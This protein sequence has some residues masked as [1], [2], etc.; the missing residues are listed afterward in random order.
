MCPRHLRNRQRTAPQKIRDDINPRKDHR[1][2]NRD[3]RRLQQN[4]RRSIVGA[5]S[6]SPQE[7]SQP[8]HADRKNSRRDH[9]QHRRNHEPRRHH[10][11]HPHDEGDEK[12]Q[13]ATRSAL[14]REAKGRRRD[15]RRGKS[16]KM[17]M[18]R[19]Q[20][21][22]RL[23]NPHRPHPQPRSHQPSSAH[24]QIDPRKINRQ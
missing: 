15:H 6:A 13:S 16:R 8:R 1:H 11:R 21:P 23:L 20:Q 3:R 14:T 2:E 17:K 19:C 10:K 9:L 24:R 5:S 22:D 7:N 18:H 12:I 4:A